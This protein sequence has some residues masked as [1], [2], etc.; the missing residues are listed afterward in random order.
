[1]FLSNVC[2]GSAWWASGSRNTLETVSY[3]PLYSIRQLATLKLVVDRRSNLEFRSAEPTVCRLRRMRQAL[4]L[5]AIF[6][7]AV[8]ML[9]SI[10]PKVPI[11]RVPPAPALHPKASSLSSDQQHE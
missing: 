7:L 6:V 1:M 5:L 4:M 9:G 11:I 2:G 8:G 10:S 3:C